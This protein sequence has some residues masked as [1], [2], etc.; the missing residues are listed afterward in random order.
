MPDVNVGDL[1]TTTLQNQSEIWADN[2]GDNNAFIALLK[3]KGKIK[4]ESGG[5][6]VRRPI[7]YA[8]LSTIM[9]FDGY[10]DLDI[11]PSSPLDTSTYQWKLMSASVSI[12]GKEALMNKGSKTQLFN[13]L[14][15]RTK[16]ARKSMMN[17][18]DTAL[19]GDGTAYA[20][21]VLGGLQQYVSTTP[22]SGT[23]GGINRATW[24]FW[25]N[26]KRQSSAFGVTRSSANIK[27]ELNAAMTPLTRG[28]ED[29]INLWLMNDTD[30]NYLQESQQAIQRIEKTDL[31]ESGFDALAHRGATC[32]LAGGYG[33]H[34]TSTYNYGLN[35][36]YW[37]LTVHEDLYMSPMDPETRVPVNQ[38][39]SVQLM[40]LMAALTCSNFALQTVL[41]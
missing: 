30:Y 41:Y 40:G 32:V 24:S 17:A 18:V 20:G 27:S 14:E 33:G 36:D 28:T 38:Y 6:D 35:L 26:S 13:L 29:K 34:I 11:T 4:K 5:Y 31:G 12:S 8:D 25:Q 9:W 16:V 39:A 10:D 22:T 37:D 23:V 19:F 15:S 1:L 21:K 7:M 2:F 3:K